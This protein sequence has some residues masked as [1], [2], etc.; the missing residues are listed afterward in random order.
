MPTKA[1]LAARLSRKGKAGRKS[2]NGT[3]RTS[4]EASKLN[5]QTRKIVQIWFEYVAIAEGE[6]PSI[7][8]GWINATLTIVPQE[9]R[10]LRTDSDWRKLVRKRIEKQLQKES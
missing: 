2:L 9:I 4:A 5:Y 6:P 3:P 7:S 10:T 8:D 1:E